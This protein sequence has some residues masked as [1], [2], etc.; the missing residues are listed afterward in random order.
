MIENPALARLDAIRHGFLTRRGG[1]SGGIY[2]S[3]NCSPGSADRLDN[4]IENRAR[5]T[6]RLGVPRE[7]LCTLAQ[8]HG[9]DVVT[10]DSPWDLTDAPKADAM[11]T[12]RPQIALGILTADCAPV[13][14][15]DAEAGVIGAAHAG[16]KGACNGVI[17]RTVEAMTALGAEPRRMVGCIGPTIGQK[18]YEVGPELRTAFIDHNDAD[19]A[20]FAPSPRPGHWLFDLGAL[21]ASRLAAAGVETVKRLNHDTCTEEE[22][23]FSYRRSCNRH[24]PDFGRQLSAIMRTS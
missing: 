19:G 7:S 14:L 10:V 1:A 23:F 11:V 2:R 4:V 12:D 22:L 18:S 3:L 21:A 13:L 5:A 8:V 24:E 6:G 9:S 17:A 15:A 16:W 20:F